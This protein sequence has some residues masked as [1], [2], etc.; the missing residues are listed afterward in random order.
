MKAYKGFNKDMTCRG[1]QFKEGETYEESEAKMC[2]KGF[3]A[4]LNPLE[5]FKFYSPAKSVYH[6]VD[7]EGDVQKNEEDSKIVGKTIKIGARLDV[8]GLCRA[9]FEFV[10]SNCE[11][12]NSN[13]AGDCGSAAAGDEGSAAAGDRGSAAAGYYG[14]AAAGDEGS[15]VSRGS[16]SVEKNGIAIARGNGIK[17]KGGLGSILLLAEEFENSYEIKCWKFGI[18]DGETL[19][20]DTWYELKNGEFQEVIE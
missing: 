2:E 7:V 8:A 1:F 5:T 12:S 11:D 9:H 10:K 16:V 3:H 13:V 18:V 20:P 19:K 4:C 17:A 14:S 6:V 15:A